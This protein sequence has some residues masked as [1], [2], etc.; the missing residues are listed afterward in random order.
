MPVLQ[1]PLPLQCLG[2]DCLVVVSHPTGHFV[3]VLPRTAHMVV[4]ARH[5]PSGLGDVSTKVILKIGYG[6]P[7]PRAALF[8]VLP[9]ARQQPAACV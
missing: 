8:G 5:P 7:V 2:A 9:F 3:P 1:H 6:F 4:S